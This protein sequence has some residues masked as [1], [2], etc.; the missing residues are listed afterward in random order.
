MT[1]EPEYLELM[2]DT[3]MI[4][5]ATSR[6]AYGADSYGTPVAHRARVVRKN[7]MVRTDSGQELV[8]RTQA[9]IYGAPG[10]T[11]RDQITLPDGTHPQILSVDRFPDENGPHHEVAYM[12][13]S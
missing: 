12:G 3:V 10:I 6:N 9:W 1:I 7:Q 8:S 2:V 11:P 5:P 13:G 4:A